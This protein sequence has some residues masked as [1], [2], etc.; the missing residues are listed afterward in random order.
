MALPLNHGTPQ[1]QEPAVVAAIVALLAGTTAPQWVLDEFGVGITADIATLDDLDSLAGEILEDTV[2]FHAKDKPD[3]D[4]WWTFDEPSGTSAAQD[5][6]KVGGI[7]ATVPARQSSSLPTLFDDNS[8]AASLVSDAVSY[9]SSPLGAIFTLTGFVKWTSTTGQ[10]SLLCGNAA[11]DPF[12]VWIDSTASNRLRAGRGQAASYV[13]STG[14]IASG[15]WHHFAVRVNTSTSAIDLFIDGALDGSGT[16]SGALGTSTAFVTGLDQFAESFVGSV[17]DI[18]VYLSAITD[19]QIADLAQDASLLAGPGASCAT[20]GTLVLGT[21]YGEIVVYTTESHWWTYT[22]PSDAT[23]AITFKNTTQRPTAVVY[24]NGSCP[25]PTTFSTNPTTSDN[26][27]ITV[28]LAS[29][30]TGDV[31]RVQV[32]DTSNASSVYSIKI[33]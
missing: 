19:A 25:T 29:L 23:Y 7:F 10:I 13:S 21:T 14:G 22:V 28:T 6:G 4:H 8:Q 31:I 3:P 24:K 26:H 17:D 1:P 12:R 20:A 18:R 33:A 30:V 9:A 16:Y 5:M 2:Y 15:A 32:S 11:S 27:T